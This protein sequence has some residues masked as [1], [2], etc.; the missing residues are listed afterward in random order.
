S[1]SGAYGPVRA[2]AGIV[3]HADLM[4]GDRAAGVLEAQAAI[5]PRFKGIR[6]SASADADP[7][8]LGPLAGRPLELMAD[9]T[10]RAG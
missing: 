5:T 6:H 10:F 2:C 4:L 7:K 3:G 1:A 9:T 8:V